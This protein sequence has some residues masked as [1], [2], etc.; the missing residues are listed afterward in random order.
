MDY[1]AVA[2]RY[3]RRYE[4]TDYRGVG[5]AL[6]DFFGDEPTRRVLELGCGTGHWLALL[7]Q[8]GF[9]N[10][11]GLDVSSRMLA[12]AAAKVRH[13][14]LR[15]EAAEQPSW[16]DATFDRVFCVN[17]LHH[18]R[19]RPLVVA[20]VRRLLRQGGG[21]LTV[22]LDP[23]VGTDQWPV[24]DY[25]DGAL[26]ADG[27]R[28]PSAATIRAWLT[29]AGFAEVRTWEA[30]RLRRQM[31][32]R[33]VLAAGYLDRGATSQLTLLSDDAYREGIARLTRS[34]DEADRRGGTLVLRSD[35]HLYG[36]VGWIRGGAGTA[37]PHGGGCSTG[38]ARR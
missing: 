20:R 34:A 37:D 12:I 27:R 25:F 3:D 13:A 28:Y 1:D 16:N 22:G 24:Y 23:S 36:T 32:A 10:L 8:R 11:A 30:A 9:V 5:T 21:F 18:F 17:A 4:G 29:A 33:E 2:H 19:D 6:E 31:P 7:A 14:D 15:R 38:S 35:L 26:E